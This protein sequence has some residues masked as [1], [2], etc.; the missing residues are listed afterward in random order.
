MLLNTKHMVKTDK[1]GIY[2]LLTQFQIFNLT[3]FTNTESNKLF[4]GKAQTP[5]CYFNLIKS[6][7]KGYIN[8]ND[9][10]LN[11]NLNYNFVIKE[12]IPVC[13]YSII[14]KI[15]Y[16]TKLFNCKLKVYKTNMPAKN[17]ISK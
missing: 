6:E 8:V 2:N 9:Q 12:P 16:V 15:K 1:Q 4:K 3:C 10:L 11:T 5:C 7:N 17:N 13:G 14:E